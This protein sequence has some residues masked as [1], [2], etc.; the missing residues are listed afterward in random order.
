[1]VAV[2]LRQRVQVPATTVLS[3]RRDRRRARYRFAIDRL[4]T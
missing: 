1:M 3:D 2:V 4:P